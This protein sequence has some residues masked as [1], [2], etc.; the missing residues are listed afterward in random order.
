MPRLADSDEALDHEARESGGTREKEALSFA[1]SV[2]FI[3]FVVP[4]PLIIYR[5]LPG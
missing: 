3:S 4:M 2:Y 5:T 1:V